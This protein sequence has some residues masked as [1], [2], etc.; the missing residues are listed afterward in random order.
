MKAQKILYHLMVTFVL[1]MLTNL[2]YSI[3]HLD[4]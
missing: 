4:H 1:W 2:E 3:P